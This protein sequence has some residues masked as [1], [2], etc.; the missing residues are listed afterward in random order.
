MQKKNLFTLFIFVVTTAT[1][2][3]TNELTKTEFY[4]TKFNNQ[5]FANL[6]KTD[7]Q[8]PKITKLLGFPDSIREGQGG[9]GEG[10]KQYKFADGFIVGYMDMAS[11]DFA[12]SIS[13]IRATSITVQGV[14]A[15]IGDHISVFGSDVDLFTKPDGK[16]AIRFTVLDNNCC[17]ITIDYDQATNLI[18]KIEY[19]AGVKV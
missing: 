11:A 16:S 4:E 9:A 8:L 15:N 6:S 13:Y 7:A 12:T 1:F 17:P 5:T 3:Q 14:T 10:W 19:V 18:T 2:A